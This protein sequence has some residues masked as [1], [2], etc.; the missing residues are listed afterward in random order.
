MALRGVG[1]YGE[2]VYGALVT[3]DFPSVLGFGVRKR[4]GRPELPDPLGV[5]GIW[6]MRMT[7]KGKK[8]LRV[9]FYDY[10]I[11][12]TTPQDANRAKFAAAMTA[13][14]ALTSEQKAGYNL[15]AKKRQTFGW[16][17]FIREYYKNN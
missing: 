3:G 14:G 6:Q 8:P 10:V 2:A 17:L 7:K 9:R 15:N 4:L 12:H 11:T 16:C 13:W 5:F 1:V